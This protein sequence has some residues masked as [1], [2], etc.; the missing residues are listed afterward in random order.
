[1]PHPVAPG[2]PDR[3][4]GNNPFTDILHYGRSEFGEPVDGVVKGMARMPGFAAVADEITE[5]LWNNLPLGRKKGRDRLT[6]MALMR[7]D[8]IKKRL[9]KGL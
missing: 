1:M 6:R 3:E 2:S 5:I 4:P 7:L 9:K 8:E